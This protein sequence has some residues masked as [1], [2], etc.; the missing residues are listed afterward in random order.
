MTNVAQSRYI[1]LE[2]VDII[3]EKRHDSFYN[4]TEVAQHIYI[5]FILCET[6]LMLWVSE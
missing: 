3:Y 6:S 2:T 4:V 1:Y 5:I